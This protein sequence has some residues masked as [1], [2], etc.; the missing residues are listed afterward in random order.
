LI[1]SFIIDEIEPKLKSI[2][3][4]SKNGDI[5]SPLIDDDEAKIFKV[6]GFEK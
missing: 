6:V 2:I 5:L 1:G 4:Y 3:E